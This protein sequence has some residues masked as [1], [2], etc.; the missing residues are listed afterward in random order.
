MLICTLTVA[1][2][3]GQNATVGY[4]FAVNY[5]DGI[6]VYSMN[7]TGTLTP[8]PGSPFPAGINPSNIFVE[9]AGRFR[10]CG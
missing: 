8:V 4:V 9:P 5:F 10:V 7:Q 1:S 3:H 2:L 6:T